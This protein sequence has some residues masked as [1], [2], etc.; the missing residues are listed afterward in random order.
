MIRSALKRQKCRFQS[1]SK[2]NADA[3]ASRRT[4]TIKSGPGN[5][6]GAIMLMLRIDC[7]IWRYFVADDAAACCG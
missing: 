5:S 1:N 2:F 6:N 3:D 4:P 7:K